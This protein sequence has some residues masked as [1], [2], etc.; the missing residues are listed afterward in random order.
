[1]EYNDDLL[2]EN[3]EKMAR[4]YTESLSKKGFVFVRLSDSQMKDSLLSSL[5]TNIQTLWQIY[6]SLSLSHMSI[7]SRNLFSARKASSNTFGE[8]AQNTSLIID[9]LKTLYPSLTFQKQELSPEGIPQAVRH[10]LKLLADI[11]CDIIKLMEEDPENLEKLK[12]I[13][14]DFSLQIKS[15]VEKY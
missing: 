5:A 1:M 13:L 10:I 12:S 6:T 8:L 15:M 7:L 3:Y 11:I 14:N 9:S 2:L 4:A